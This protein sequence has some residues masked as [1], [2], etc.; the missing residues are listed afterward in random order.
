M[1][2]MLEVRRDGPVWTVIIN[3]PQRR[4]AL[5][6]P[7]IDALLATLDE[8]GRDSYCLALVLTGAGSR[9][10]CAGSDIKAAAELDE[11]GRIAHTAH[12]QRLIRELESHRC[13]IVAAIEGFAL[14]GGLE[15]ALA[16]DLRVAG[17]S[18]IFGMPELS[19]GMV[20]AWGGTFRLTQA[21]G[22]ART[23]LMVLGGRRYTA[24]DAVAFGLVADAVPDGQSV[25]NAR[26]LA[27]QVVGTVDVGGLARAKALLRV[28][29]TADRDT[30][31]LLELL[32]ESAQATGAGYL[33]AS[34]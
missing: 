9:A 14:G 21:I 28:G 29:V 12:G 22:L 10:F 31:M 19:L 13:L 17:R 30:G 25:Q 11:A 4:N 1:S 5:D 32:G 20:P 23:Q 34:G 16:C 27:A 7:T 15:L 3:R 2:D 24:D 33:G 26:D 6:D 18:A 8:A